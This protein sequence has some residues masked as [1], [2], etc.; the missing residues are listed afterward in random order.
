MAP[1]CR[2]C[3]SCCSTWN[4]H[5]MSEWECVG[6]ACRL[7]VATHAMCHHTC[8]SHDLPHRALIGQPASTPQVH[9]ADQVGSRSADRA[10]R[11]RRHGNVP[12]PLLPS[13]SHDC[14]L[15]TSALVTLSLYA[16]D[17]CNFSAC[18][19][20]ASALYHMQQVWLKIMLIPATQSLCT[21]RLAATPT[22]AFAWE[23]RTSQKWLG[24]TRPYVSSAPRQPAS[25]Y[26]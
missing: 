20:S 16:S 2:R 9:A 14:T 5:T 15:L 13:A 1:L 10:G 4:R 18:P 3:A 25:N 19:S 7:L 8:L 26:T 24:R 6:L 21:L 11:T 23:F 12:V 22:A 17:P